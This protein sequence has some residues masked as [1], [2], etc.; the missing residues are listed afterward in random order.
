MLNLVLLD[1]EKF[2]LK[3]ENFHEFNSSF[4]FVV[5]LA[6]SISIKALRLFMSSLSVNQS[7]KTIKL[8]CV[9]FEIQSN[10]KSAIALE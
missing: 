10:I 9:C 5:M 4:C 2:Y 8:V 3:F 7:S 6:E 1:V